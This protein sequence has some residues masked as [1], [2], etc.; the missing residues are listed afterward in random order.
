MANQALLLCGISQ[1]IT[2]DSPTDNEH[3]KAIDLFLDT[4]IETCL[5]EVKYD[6][7]RTTYPITKLQNKSGYQIP[8][9]YVRFIGLGACSGCTSQYEDFPVDHNVQFTIQDCALFIS[10]QPCCC[11]CGESEKGV[12]VYTTSNFCDSEPPSL[13][14]EAC[15]MYLA[16]QLSNRFGNDLNM[17]NSLIARSRELLVRAA[18]NQAKNHQRVAGSYETHCSMPFMGTGKGRFY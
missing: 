7:A 13:F 18:K 15:S 5:Q 6:F 17:T 3:K 16:S 8:P 11:C 4:S 10:K 14:L 1:T 2:S 12:I 9:N